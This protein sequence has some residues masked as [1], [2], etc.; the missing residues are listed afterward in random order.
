MGKD[1]Q[2][3]GGPHLV[4]SI[5]VELSDEGAHPGVSEIARQQG[6]LKY[7]DVLDDERFPILAPLNDGRV[8]CLSKD[9]LEFGDE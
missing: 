2:V 9:L 7:F 6:L 3:A 5:H 1:D 8:L 4:E